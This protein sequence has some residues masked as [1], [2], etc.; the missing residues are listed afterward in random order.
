MRH[1]AI[2]LLEVPEGPAAATS[3]QNNSGLPKDRLTLALV[4]W[5]V[6]QTD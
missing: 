6:R 4:G 3:I 1:S 5:K 2:R